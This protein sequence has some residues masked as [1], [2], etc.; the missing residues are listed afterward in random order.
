[1]RKRT[2]SRRLLDL[3]YAEGGSRDMSCD[4]GNQE[5]PLC[6][7]GR[8]CRD[9]WNLCHAVHEVPDCFLEQPPGEETVGCGQFGTNEQCR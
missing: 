2:S 4:G 5:V 9:T 6:A 8:R 3:G 7:A 1:M